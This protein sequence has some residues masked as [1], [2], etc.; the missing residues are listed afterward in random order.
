[1]SEQ[2]FDI[3]GL[4]RYLHLSVHQVERLVTRGNLPA[5][6]VA[7]KWRFSRAEIH[8]WME[9]RMG[10]LEGAELSHVEGALARADNIASQDLAISQMLHRESIRVALEAKTKNSVIEEMTQLAAATGYLWDPDAMADA[11]RSRE[12]LQSTA[13]DNG[14]A[15]MHPRRPLSDILA[16]PLL[17]VGVSAQGI[18]FGGS[19]RLTDVFFLIASCDDRGHLRTLARLSRLLTSE[20]FLSAIRS[21]QD[22]QELH[23]VISEAEA[24]LVI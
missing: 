12:Q 15:L 13:M 6:K 5:R 18:P 4:A 21:A 1:M 8:H 20:G 22:A 19:H 23:D 24:K 7:Q 11:I 10:V 9:E 14:V 2:D 16:E 3:E 17:A